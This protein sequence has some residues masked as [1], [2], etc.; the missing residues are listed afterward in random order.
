M[1]TRIK[2]LYIHVPFCSSICS[3]CDFCHRLYDEKIV[4]QWLETL[5]R[6]IKAKCVNQYETIYIG[7]GT[8]S[9][10]NYEQ[11]ETMLTLLK[12]YTSCVK[13]Y[14]IEVNPE[15]IDE[16]KIK[17][18]KKYD[19][20]RISMGVQSSNS[21]L[22]KLMNRKHSFEDVK[23]KIELL[24]KYDLKNISID[25]IYSL[26]TQTMNLLKNTIDDFLSLKI[27]HVSIYSL[28]VEKNTIFAA[29]KY[30]PLDEE[31]EADM[32]EYIVSTLNKNAYKQ[33]EVSN[34]ALE[35]FES[36]HNIG[37]WRYE[38][39]L[40]LS[41]NATSKI[42]NRRYTNTNKFLEYFADFNATIE[43]EYLDH[44]D[45]EFEAIMMGLRMSKGIDILDFNKRF[46]VNLLN[47][48]PFI[49]KCDK[50]KIING[51]LRVK[52]LEL[53]NS[54]LLDFLD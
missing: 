40:G 50:L 7:G 43:D 3:Y 6:E 54:I 30:S 37:Y 33:Y 18:L 4:K 19:I 13:E 44:K 25:L 49:E 20:N 29:K 51:Y 17:L 46:D 39:Y 23:E 8:P 14:T 21:K 26:P 2:H 36:K 42:A 16:E 11:L 45:L 5:S 48:Y 41:L 52:N 22:L 9:C 32:Y 34:F 10:L 47:D 15:S 12:P 28:T 31:I 53:L 1:T 27:P 35:G 24:K 38:D